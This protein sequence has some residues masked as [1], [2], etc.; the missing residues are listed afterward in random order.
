MARTNRVITETSTGSPSSLPNG[1]LYIERTVVNTSLFTVYVVHPDGSE[2]ELLPYTGHDA[3]NAN[4]V[5]VYQ[6]RHNG[7]RR[8]PA[9]HTGARKI[10]SLPMATVIVPWQ[11]I[12][13]HGTYYDEVSNLLFSKRSGAT[14]P[15]LKD[16]YT[17]T[18]VGLTCTHKSAVNNGVSYFLNNP[19]QKE[20]YV[21]YHAV[22]YQSAFPIYCTNLPRPEGDNSPTLTVVTV[23]PGEEHLI[24]QEVDISDLLK[25][26]H[27]SINVGGIRFAIGVTEDDATACYAQLNDTVTKEVEA[28]VRA[29]VSKFHKDMEALGAENST[30]RNEVADMNRQLSSKQKEIVHLRE[31]RLAA[32]ERLQ[33]LEA[34]RIAAEQKLNVEKQ[35]AA[36]KLAEQQEKTARAETVAKSEALKSSSNIFK[37]IGMVLLAIIPAVLSWMSN[38]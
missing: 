21:T 2:E 38:N 3:G 34:D 12:N 14:H 18:V 19:K 31:E 37:T 15:L 36:S 26:G 24:H 23:G 5:T 13:T 10:K 6:L 22:G 20:E 11:V 28:G 29:G 8:Y 16:S 27:V 30:L 4:C 25:D 33:R 32:F 17:E 9:T 35:L 7:E 1:G